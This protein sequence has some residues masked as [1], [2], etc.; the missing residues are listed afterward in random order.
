M[1]L[2]IILAFSCAGCNGVQ[3]F[4]FEREQIS[5]KQTLYFVALP[6][7]EHRIVQVTRTAED[8]KE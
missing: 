3:Q 5:N 8:R 2:A 6:M 4:C 7:D 1:T